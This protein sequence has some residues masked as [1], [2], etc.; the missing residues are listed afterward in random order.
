M[1]LSALQAAGTAELLRPIMLIRHAEDDER[2][3]SLSARGWQ[4]A[5]AL[6]RLFAPLD[7]SVL[8]KHLALPRHIVAARSDEHSTRALDT[9]QPLAEMLELPVDDS[10]GSDDPPAQ[11]AQALRALDAPV[12]VCWRH[13]AE[14]AR[15]APRRGVGD[16]AR[17]RKRPPGAGAATGAAWRSLAVDRATRAARG[18]RRAL[19]AWLPVATRR[20]R[21][22]GTRLASKGCYETFD[23]EQDDGTRSSRGGGPGPGLAST[24]IRSPQRGDGGG[25]AAAFDG[26]RRCP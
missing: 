17:R 24:A 16:R 6:V 20:W 15:R 9:V 8:R 1:A 25:A 18:L 19:S 2:S 22:P 5:G 12:L 11:V 7:A 14:V 3:P 21:R 10:L 23:G 4:R 13:D 26:T